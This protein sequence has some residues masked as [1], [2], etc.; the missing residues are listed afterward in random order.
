MRPEDAPAGRP[1]LH[2][3]GS[4]AVLWLAEGCD[5]ICLNPACGAPL[6]ADQPVNIGHASLDCGHCRQRVGIC[7]ARY[8]E[9]GL[10]TSAAFLEQ[11]V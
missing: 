9:A 6:L 5:E 8:I 7:G 4:G 3:C 1:V 2:R 11:Y 10:A